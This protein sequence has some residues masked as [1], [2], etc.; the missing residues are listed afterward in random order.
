MR[1]RVAVVYTIL[2]F[3]FISCQDKP[4]DFTYSLKTED[5]FPDSLFS[6]VSIIPLDPS[7]PLLYIQ[8]VALIDSSFYILAHNGFFKYDYSGQFVRQISRRG[9]AEQEWLR[10]DTF[11]Y[12]EK[13]K[14]ICLVDGGASKIIHFS[15]D[16]DFLYSSAIQT[17]RK[18]FLNQVVELED[19]GILMANSILNEQNA[20]YLYSPDNTF[21]TVVELES[22]P[23]SSKAIQSIGL[24]PISSFEGGIKCIAPVSNVISR[25]NEGQLLKDIIIPATK[26]VPDAKVFRDYENEYS[27]YL[28]AGICLKNDLFC[29]YDAVFETERYIILTSFDQYYTIVDKYQS[30][31]WVLTRQEWLKTTGILFDHIIDKSHNTLISAIDG[32]RV[33]NY[34]RNAFLMSHCKEPIKSYLE[35]I[36]DDTESVALVLYTLRE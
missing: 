6:K 18:C 8:R 14:D 36:E 23:Y 27:P 15:L 34:K 11:F 13:N 30:D 17:P 19:G 4:A 35:N 9:R 21:N 20:I 2:L 26:P 32:F 29:G 25:M 24:C 1:Y 5:T 12:S 31:C 3:F 16:G 10:L 7:N 28:F 33:D 22:V